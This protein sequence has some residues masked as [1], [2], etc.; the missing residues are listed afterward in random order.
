MDLADALDDYLGYLAVERGSSANTVQ[1]YGRDLKRYIAF[2]GERGIASPE[3]VTRSDIEAHLAGLTD[4]GLAA[5]SVQ[6]AASAI[7]GFHKFMV[8]EQITRNHPSANLPLPRRPERLPEVLTHE[9]AFAL[10]D[11][12]FRPELEPRPRVLRGGR[13]DARPQ[14]VFHR[15]KAMLEVLYG[16]GLRVSELC[17]LDVRD[18]M[19][20]EEVLRVM[21]KG[22][23][24]RLV[25]LLGTAERALA[26][27]L[28]RWRGVLSA[29]GAAG[30]AV[31]L[32]ERGTRITRQAVHRMVER[33]GRLV[34]I[35]GLH[36]HTLR[37][38][39]ATHMLEGGMDLRTVQELLGHAS[40]STTQ[41]YTHID[42]THVRMV[43]LEA[44]PRA[45]MGS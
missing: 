21:G 2:L 38:T 5:S 14:A 15:D 29:S 39:Y 31:F 43:Y 17:G 32:S 1:S 42:L 22:S 36:P 8:G 9:Q 4:A 24:E 18:V 40:I 23:K 45:R 7:K 27:Y 13:L 20:D 44:H 16:C 35:E 25:P 41:L 12:P 11:E 30:D 3:D 37:H 28:E 10:M 26:T 6:R 19:L 34:G 33:Y